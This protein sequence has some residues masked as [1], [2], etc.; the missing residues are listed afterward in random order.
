MFEGFFNF[1]SHI[2]ELNFLTL[3]YHRQ[4]VAKS[5]VQAQI[6]KAKIC[7]SSL[8]KVDTLPNTRCQ[9]IFFYIFVNIY[10]NSICTKCNT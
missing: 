3:L 2:I 8:I 10:L 6:Y 1:S 4:D 7:E 9:S 5:V